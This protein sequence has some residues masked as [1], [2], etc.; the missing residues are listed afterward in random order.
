MTGAVGVLCEEALFVLMEKR[1]EEL[2]ALIKSEWWRP[3]QNSS[4]ALRF[5]WAGAATMEGLQSAF[6]DIVGPGT[7]S[8]EIFTFLLHV[9]IA[10]EQDMQN[11]KHSS[12]ASKRGKSE[13]QLKHNN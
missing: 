2:D 6:R 1:A 10:F 13:C 3:C 7:E 9:Q 8:S 5:S 11:V 4:C 12:Q